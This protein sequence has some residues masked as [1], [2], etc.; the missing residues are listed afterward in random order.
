MS[1]TAHYSTTEIR[2]WLEKQ[3]S[4]ILSPVQAQAK[5]L[6]DDLNMA[7]QSVAE[8]AKLLLDNSA[9]E[10][11]RR[12]MRVYNRARALNKLA[13]LFLDRLKKL[14]VPDEVTYDSLSRYAQD[15]QKVFVVTDIDIKNWFP[16]ISPFFIMDRRR[17]L[18]V[19]EKAKQSLAV[20][21]DFLSKEYIK[22]KTLEETF[23][24][25]NSLHNLE[26]E[27]VGLEEEKKR[28]MSE[29]VPIEQEIEELER[30]I[31]Q[32]K[33]DGPVDQ[34]FTV[35]AEIEQLNKELKH[36]LR[37]L[38]KPFIKVQALALHG[39]GAGLTP[40]ELNTLNMY[41]EQPFKALSTEETGYPMLK[42]VLEKLARLM[43]EDK[44]KLK[45]DKARKA[46]QVVNDIVKMN[47][48][49]KIHSRCVEVAFRE[50][51]ILSSTKMEEIKSDLSTLQTQ[52]ERLRARKASVEAHEAVKERAYNETLDKI[53]GTKR[54]IEKN[55][56]TSLGQ[57]IHIL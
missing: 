55:V 46:E 32:L 33:S 48:L 10:I 5:R 36:K 54:A 44:L 47:S 19:H 30:K 51:Q 31:A 23:Q 38:Q 12:N 14:T 27:L 1:E 17:F 7:V 26:N 6:R 49:A 53:A 43:T 40:D 45:S 25:I 29:R 20:L 41:L 8:V 28:L 34:L 3:T 50:R 15:V 52:V 18:S 22:T 21:N 37:H 56:Y 11:E 35:E 24:L 57:K 16:R 13:R 9:K 39:G 4:S 2:S 42:Q